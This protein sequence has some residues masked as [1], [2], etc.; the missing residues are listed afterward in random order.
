MNNFKKNIYR[1]SIEEDIIIF[2]PFDHMVVSFT[3]TKPTNGTDLDI[4]IYY[5]DTGTIYDK[6]AVGYNQIP[7]AIKLPTD[8]TLDTDAY[9]WWA[10]DDV[11]SPPGV[12]VEAVVLGVKNFTDNVTVTGD[13]INIYLRAGW[14]STIGDGSVTVNLKTYLG[15]TMSKVG[16]DIINT[17]GTL[18][19]NQSKNIEVTSGTGQVTEAHSNLLG[20]V[21]YNKITKA[22]ILL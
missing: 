9:L 14:F 17:G 8:A 18:V 3:Y 16:T 12:C 7:D 4:M 22:A 1:L 13:N 20:T 21:Q 11:R 15:G 5:D 19:D 2:D 10:N 6:N